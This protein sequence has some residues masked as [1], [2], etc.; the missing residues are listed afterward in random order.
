MTAA[1][2][3]GAGAGLAA[4]RRFVKKPPAAGQCELCALPLAE[5]H[6]H[7]VNPQSRQLLCACLPC[8]ILFGSG[9]ETQY[10]RVPRDI[11]YLTQFKL[12]E[13]LWNSLMIPIELVFF[14]RSS[15]SGKMVALYPSPAG[16]TESLLDLELWSEVAAENPP[17]DNML[18]D[19][20]ALLVNRANN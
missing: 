4:L 11:R 13:Q 2:K 19:V 14:Y 5:R 10:R 17:L 1:I 3:P 12:S 20:E 18:A 9:G 8:A 6:E 16:P 7:L 15:A